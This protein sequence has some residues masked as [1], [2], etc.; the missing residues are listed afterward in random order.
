M[1]YDAITLTG[2]GALTYGGT[3]TVNLNGT[4]PAAGTTYD[5]FDFATETGT[6]SAINVTN[7]GS[8]FGGTFDYTTGV[9]TLTA[10][11]EP[12]TWTGG[13]LTLGALGYCVRRRKAGAQAAG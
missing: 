3:L 8:S 10:V 12:S 7:G 5:L 11:P 9:L 2:A 4:T 1:T 13:V 6:F